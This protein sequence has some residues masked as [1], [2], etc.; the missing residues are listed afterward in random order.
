MFK[1]QYF[2]KKDLKTF[3]KYGYMEFEWKQAFTYYW[4]FEFP[5]STIIF[6]I[7]HII[8]DLK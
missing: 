1:K 5:L 2:N 4:C 6:I 8:K 7:I 3:F